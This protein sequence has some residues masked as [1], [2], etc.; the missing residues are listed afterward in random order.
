MSWLFILRIYLAV[1]VV[2]TV[3]GLVYL[4]RLLQ[5]KP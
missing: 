5:R 3:V 2:L 1:L 4:A